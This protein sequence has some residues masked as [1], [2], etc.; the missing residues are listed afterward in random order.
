MPFSWCFLIQNALF[1]NFF[2]FFSGKTSSREFDKAV[3]EKELEFSVKFDGYAKD[4][5]LK[6]M[7]RDPEYR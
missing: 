6:L 2:S 7:E 1:F 5:I 3:L 4:L